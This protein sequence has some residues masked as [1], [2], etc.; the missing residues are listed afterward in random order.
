MK[1]SIII[2]III[3]KIIKENNVLMK[4]NEIIWKISNEK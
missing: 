1:I 3:L 4:E 2:I